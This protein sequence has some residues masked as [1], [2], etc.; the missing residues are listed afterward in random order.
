MLALFAFAMPVLETSA[1]T[2]PHP[3]APLA[4]PLTASTVQ[5]PTLQGLKVLRIGEDIY[6][7]VIDPQ[8][9]SFV[10]EIAALAL[11][12]E[13]LTT[14]DANGQ[15]EPAAAD[16]FD[17]SDD[18]MVVTAHIRDGLKRAD[19]TPITAQDFVYALRRAVDPRVPGKQY[20]S[21]LFDLKGAR[22]LSELP[23]TTSDADIEEAYA[24]YGVRAVDDSTL[25]LTFTEPVAS[26]WA[27]LASMPVFYPVDQT[28]VEADPENW[29]K[30][31]SNHNGNGPFA[32]SEINGSSKI[33]FTA[34]ENYWR[35]Q[36][37]LDRIEVS[38][39][40]DN[41]ATLEA[42]E[43]GELDINASLVA[44]QVPQVISDT[45]V[46]SEYLHYP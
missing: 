13:G 15:V 4:N 39:N 43:N 41:D 14:I 24:D 31:P 1:Q 8:R 42:Y 12:Y 19:G 25:E 3:S 11:A 28:L 26:Y 16:R 17:V 7:A 38:Y 23:A 40:S 20:V 18:G 29:W 9:S 33:T 6:P 27:Y 10:N 46:I 36:P 21:L 2:V 22:A 32:F 37:M 35:G 44:E 5:S 30:D 34:N 45:T